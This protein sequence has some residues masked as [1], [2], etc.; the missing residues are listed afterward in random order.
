MTNA[1]SVLDVMRR[2]L[3]EALGHQLPAG[4]GQSLVGHV[5]KG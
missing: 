1:Q 4:E 2:R 3:E 5:R